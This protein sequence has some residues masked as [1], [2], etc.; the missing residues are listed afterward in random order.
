M[1]KS[2]VT[3]F[4]CGARFLKDN[5]EVNRA[6][7]LGRNHFCSC[8]CSGAKNAEFTRAKEIVLCCPCGKRFTTTTKAK[9]A[10]HCSRACASKF[11]MNEE[12]REAQRA[13][14]KA[15]ENRISPA[16]AL[17]KREA[18]KY[19]SLEQ[20][21]LGRRHK[22]EYELDGHVFDLALLDTGILV[23]FDGPYHEGKGQRRLDKKKEVAAARNGFV[24]VRRRVLPA[25]VV[26]AATIE[27]L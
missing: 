6:L 14:G 4:H 15:S 11:S 26:S 1:A 5:R 7:R 13:A 18:W 27:G 16:E 20:A 8:A 23:E 22:F 21:L 24:V 2:Q 12:R 19:T 25:V 17:K 3:C 9:A 10:K